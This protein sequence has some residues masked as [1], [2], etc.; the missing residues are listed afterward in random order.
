MSGRCKTINLAHVSVDNLRK[1]A[2]K[3][4]KI[5]KAL[6]RSAYEECHI[7]EYIPPP[8]REI[9]KA[10]IQICRP[11][12]VDFVSPP[13]PC[14]CAPC[15]V[16]PSR[17]EQLKNLAKITL[18]IA[19]FYFLV[20]AT[21]KKQI[22]GTPDGT[23]QMVTNFSNSIMRLFKKNRKDPDVFGGERIGLIEPDRIRYKL[24]SLWDK[25]IVFIFTWTIGVPVQL[26]HDTFS[27]IETAIIGAEDH[28]EDQ[29]Q[30]VA[31]EG[32]KDSKN[33]QNKKET[34][35]QGKTTNPEPKKG[36]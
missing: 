35:S 6:E 4:Q 31:S 22:W 14:I 29:H 23:T 33:V 21:T 18:K 32:Q 26:A 10:R 17:A 11:R 36:K 13:V 28:H 8:P 34:G 20:E 2:T 16:C 15:P 7:P 19:A 12:P 24:A 27:R 30:V 9:K 25:T 1:R 5:P 3:L